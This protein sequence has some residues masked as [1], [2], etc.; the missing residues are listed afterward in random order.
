MQIHSIYRVKGRS[1]RVSRT[2]C[3]RRGKVYRKGF[4]KKDGTRVKSVCARKPKRR[5]RR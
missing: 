5:R 3:E 4:K 2:S 1:A